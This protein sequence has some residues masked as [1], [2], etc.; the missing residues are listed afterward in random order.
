MPT[1]GISRTYGKKA[2][3]SYIPTIVAMHVGQWIRAQVGNRKI[4]DYRFG[5]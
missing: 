5:F 4:V 2:L 1:F 3:N